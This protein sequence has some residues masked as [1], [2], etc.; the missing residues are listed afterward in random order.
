M[1]TVLKSLS[2]FGSLNAQ[3]LINKSRNAVRFES[4]NTLWDFEEVNYQSVA[5]SKGLASLAFQRSHLSPMQMTTS[6]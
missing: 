3:Y 6:C 5:F 4:Q 2:R 1:N